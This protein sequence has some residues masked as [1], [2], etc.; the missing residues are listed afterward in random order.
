MTEKLDK[1][2]LEIIL[3]IPPM[4]K[5]MSY[6]GTCLNNI[7]RISGCDNFPHEQIR[8]GGCDSFPKSKSES[9]GVH[10][11]SK[12]QDSSISVLTLKINLMKQYFLIH[13]S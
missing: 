3:V 6:I 1:L 10:L 4:Y 5:C 13:L 12:Y 9:N 7:S 8:N 2:L 11:F